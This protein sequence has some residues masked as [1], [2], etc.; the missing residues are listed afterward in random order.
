MIVGCAGIFCGLDLEGVISALLGGEVAVCLVEFTAPIS[1]Q[2]LK[3]VAAAIFLGLDIC[4]VKF[5]DQGDFLR[6]NFP[7][8]FKGF[9]LRLTPGPGGWAFE[10]CGDLGAQ[11]NPILRFL[12]NLALSLFPLRGY[13]GERLRR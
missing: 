8:G 6:G 2:A 11:Q 5:A 9:E 3:V 1:E 4:G 12:D 13:R 7:E 10:N